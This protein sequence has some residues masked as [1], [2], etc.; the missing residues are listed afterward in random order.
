MGC[1]NLQLVAMSEAR[2]QSLSKL[3]P[4]AG[5]GKAKLEK[6]G[7][8][9]LALLA[10]PRGATAPRPDPAG[11][12]GSPVPATAMVPAEPPSAEAAGGGRGG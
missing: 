3:G 1:T 6:Y 7:Q 9:I 11:D 8:E 10:W 2:P 5:I 4:V 12:S